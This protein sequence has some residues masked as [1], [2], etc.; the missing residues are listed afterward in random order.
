[1]K[2]MLELIDVSKRFGGVVTSDKVSLSVPEGSIHG[3]IGPNG[4]GKTTLIN[5]I[6][7]IVEMDGGKIVFDGKDITNLSSYARARAGIGRTF[8]VPRFLKNSSIRDNLLLGIDLRNGIGDLKSFL[9]NQRSSLDEDL[10]PLMEAAGFR[11]KWSDDI[12]ELTFGQ[13]KLLEIVRAMLSH[14]KV[15]LVD[16]PAAG[17]NSKEIER[18]GKLLTMAAHERNIAVLVIEHRMDLM[19]EI[20]EKMY[21]LVF[22]KLIAEGLPS[23][24]T[25]QPNVIEAYLGSD[26]K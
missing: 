21:V 10:E 25:A 18:V 12:S 3:L 22:G 15:M 16:E 14:P 5:L 26:Y 9:G 19:I 6:S 24:V 8:Q 1:M 4:A 7:G 13:M 23:E 2:P 11:F 17:L 20:S